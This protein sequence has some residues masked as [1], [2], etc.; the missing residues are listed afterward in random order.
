MPKTFS[1]SPQLPIPYPILLVG[2]TSD[3][4]EKDFLQKVAQ[5]LSKT[6]APA[7]V[8]QLKQ[9]IP[10]PSLLLLA[11]LSPKHS[12]KFNIHILTQWRGTYFLPLAPLTSYIQDPQ[13]KR[14][15]WN[16]LKTLP[17]PL[18]AS[19]IFDLAV[20]K[21]LDYGIPS[22]SSTKQKKVLKSVFS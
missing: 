14:D 21:S 5:T 19:V 13:L 8:L 9:R 7:T 3:S 2:F 15:L 4:L 22:L 17:F 18:Y 10:H 12:D 11:P 20:G 16:A 1:C 6:L